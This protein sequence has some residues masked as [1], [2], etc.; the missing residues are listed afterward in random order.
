MRE[1]DVGS[2]PPMGL[3]HDT[4]CS[5]QSLKRRI[6]TAPDDGNGKYVDPNAAIQPDTCAPTETGADSCDC[7][8]STPFPCA[9]TQP[10]TCSPTES[11]PE[12]ETEDLGPRLSTRFAARGRLFPHPD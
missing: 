7:F 2:S 1:T 4:L 5:L 10:D 11:E 9:A 12:S 8:V 3:G 6:E